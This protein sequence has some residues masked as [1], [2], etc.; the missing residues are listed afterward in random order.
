[1]TTEQAR[2]S[3]YFEDEEPVPSR[4]RGGL[5]GSPDWDRERER[6]DQPEPIRRRIRSQENDDD[7]DFYRPRRPSRAAIPERAASRGPTTDDWDRPGR[8]QP[9]APQARVPRARPSDWDEPGE[10]SDRSPGPRW[11]ASA[12]RPEA[13][14][15]GARR[16]ER[17][18]GPELRR[19]SRPSPSPENLPRSSRRPGDAPGPGAPR[20]AAGAG[21]AG[22]SSPGVPQGTPISRGVPDGGAVR[23]ADFSPLD[24]TAPRPSRPGG[25]AAPPARDNSSRFDD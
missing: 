10:A 7:D 19:G 1:V 3:A 20:A 13:A 4:P 22:Y 12:A 11:S 9:S 2:R 24:D 16:R 23:D 6:L 18:S 17:E 25:G 8:D 14:P 5:G 21:G 15:F